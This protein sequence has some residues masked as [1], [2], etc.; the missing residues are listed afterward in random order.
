[1]RGFCNEIFTIFGWIGAVLATIL[2]TPVSREVLRTYIDSHVLA[3]L[4]TASAIFIITMIVFSV[5]S[6]YT[7]KSLQD[8][9]LSAVD[10]SL[11]FAFGILRAVVLLGLAFLLICWIW[12]PKDRPKAIQKSHT[13]PLLEMSATLVQVIIPGDPS[14]QIHADD[15]DKSELDDVMRPDEDTDDSVE[16]DKDVKPDPLPGTD[17]PSETDKPSSPASS[18]KDS[19]P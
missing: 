4:A 11:G 19:S 6:H 12:E 16:P 3:D 7:T 9:K 15:K 10:R 14:I 2:L 8:S 13:R 18:E 1:M 17:T 5:I